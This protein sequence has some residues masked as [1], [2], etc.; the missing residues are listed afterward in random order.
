[1]KNFTETKVFQFNYKILNVSSI[2]LP[3]RI[4]LLD[5]FELF[6]IVQKFC[7]SSIDFSSKCAAKKVTSSLNQA[8]FWKYGIRVHY[9]WF[10]T[11]SNL[12]FNLKR[13]AVGRYKR[14]YK[15]IAVASTIHFYFYTTIIKAHYFHLV[16]SILL[17]TFNSGIENRMATLWKFPLGIFAV[18][19]FS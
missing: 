19:L 10:P 1:M 7:G 11:M 12:Y 14:K 4:F 3:T 16:K 6:Q 2:L 9:W 17:Y 18:K 5:F 15:K 8:L 13:G